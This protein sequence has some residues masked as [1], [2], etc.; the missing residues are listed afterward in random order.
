MARTKTGVSEPR[1]AKLQSPQPVHFILLL[2]LLPLETPSLSQPACRERGNAP[3]ASLP[4]FSGSWKYRPVSRDSR[5]LEPWCCPGHFSP[6]T[7][8]LATR[9]GRKPV[10]GA[11][12]FLPPPSF[13]GGV[14][15][16]CKKIIF[17]INSGL[18]VG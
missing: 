3:E 4:L 6:V 12:E 11:A 18:N 1:A 13:G 8:V 5:S 17:C 15:S 7:V 9:N 2:L 14:G 10:P 16:G